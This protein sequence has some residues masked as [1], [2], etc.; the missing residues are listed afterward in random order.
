MAKELATALLA[1]DKIAVS[2]SAAAGAATGDRQAF[3]GTFNHL[4]Q[5]IDDDGQVIFGRPQLDLTDL[6]IG[7]RRAAPVFDLE[8]FN[9]LVRKAGGKPSAATT[10]LQSDYAAEMAAWEEQNGGGGSIADAIGEKVLQFAV[11]HY[12]ISTTDPRGAHAYV[13]PAQV[14]VRPA[15]RDGNKPVVFSVSMAPV[16]GQK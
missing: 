14:I 16:W 12:G 6:V 9:D 10:K 5:P 1:G 4:G 3:A 11:T 2:L 7:N 8:K 15:Y 13:D